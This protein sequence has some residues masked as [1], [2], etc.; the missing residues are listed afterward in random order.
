MLEH[1][2]GVVPERRQAASP[3][4][5][6]TLRSLLPQLRPAERRVGVFVVDYPERVQH[7]PITALAQQVGVSIGTVS[8]LS[9]TAG[10]SGYA[11]FRRRLVQDLTRSDLRGIPSLRSA[12]AALA[13]TD[14]HSEILEGVFD[15]SIQ[16]LR[17]T[18]QIIDGDAFS[19]AVA[20]LSDARLVYCFG[21]GGS[22]LVALDV[23]YRLLRIGVLAEGEGDSQLQSARAALLTAKDL[24]LAISVSG[25]H[26]QTLDT[27]H[28]VKLAGT[29]LIVM[30][31]FPRSH[32]GRLADICLHTVSR[33]PEWHREAAPSRVVQL[34]LIDALC[35][36]VM[37]RRAAGAPEAK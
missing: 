9:R 23:S 20:L 10:C 6:L 26:V 31:N 7:M 22:G 18:L 16:S 5:L 8:R 35:L 19:Q 12:S 15:L 33:Q 36:C 3:S 13:T 4:L 1:S 34:T 21:A 24:A 27:A 25:E 29:P 17:E 37:R 2:A 32:L 28:A 11:E 14:A 30:T